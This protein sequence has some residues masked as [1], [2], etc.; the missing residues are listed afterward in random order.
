MEQ[1]YSIGTTNRYAMFID[2]EDDPGDV[3]LPVSAKTAKETTVTKINKS[4]TRENSK[5]NKLAKGKDGKENKDKPSTKQSKTTENI[6]KS[7]P[8]P[9]NALKCQE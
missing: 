2:E 9:L 8:S 3:I 4:D 7:K 1:L 5:T 6:N